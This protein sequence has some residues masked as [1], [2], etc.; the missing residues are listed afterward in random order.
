MR[1]ARAFADVAR[2]SEQGARATAVLPSYRPPESS[3]TRRWFAPL[4][5][6]VAASVAFILLALQLSQS[7]APR[8]VPPGAG[9]PVV[10]PAAEPSAAAKESDQTTPY[11]VLL[12]A[13]VR[14]GSDGLHRVSIPPRVEQVRLQLEV[15]SSTPADDRATY[16]LVVRAADGQELYVAASL[17]S[18]L[19]GAFRIVESVVPARVLGTGVRR[20]ALRRS[21]GDGL[22]PVFDWEI[23][24]RADQTTP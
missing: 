5:V 24:V 21:A 9:A 7:P 12:L 1:F 18:R 23:D 13:E 3:L 20:V 11:A 8:S 10:P 22:L 19:V 15:A 16:Q 4:G 14:R 2:P 17:A 6:L